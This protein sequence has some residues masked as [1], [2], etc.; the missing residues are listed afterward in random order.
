MLH[1]ILVLKVCS[2]NKPNLN[3]ADM[4]FSKAMNQFS[5]IS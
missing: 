1:C 5:E 2:D 4:D 3:K